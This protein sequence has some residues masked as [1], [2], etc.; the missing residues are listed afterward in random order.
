MELTEQMELME[1]TITEKEF[2]E[3]VWGRL[4]R[5]L[6]AD[7]TLKLADLAPLTGYSKTSLFSFGNRSWMSIRL[8]VKLVEVLPELAGDLRCNSCQRLPNIRYV[9]H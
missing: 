8:A 9:S 4:M 6:Q 3:Y 1:Q 2:I 5:M 7:P